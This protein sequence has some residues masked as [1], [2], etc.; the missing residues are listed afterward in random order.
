ME[1]GRVQQWAGKTAAP[2]WKWTS[3]KRS[4]RK[5]ELSPCLNVEWAESRDSERHDTGMVPVTAMCRY[6]ACAGDVCRVC[7][8][9]CVSSAGAVEGKGK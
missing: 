9:R 2:T 4:L 8:R 1:G 5:S 3:A 7:G 6:C